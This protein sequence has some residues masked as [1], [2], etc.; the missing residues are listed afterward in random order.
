MKKA[1]GSDLKIRYSF[2]IGYQLLPYYSRYLWTGSNKFS[3]DIPWLPTY[4]IET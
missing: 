3:H 4:N 1:L 2:G